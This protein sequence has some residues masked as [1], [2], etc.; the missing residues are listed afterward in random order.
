M[1][2]VTI[3][4]CVCNDVFLN[5]SREEASG[6]EAWGN[7][8]LAP[9]QYL[10]AGHTAMAT[11]D[12]F[13]P[14]QMIQRFDYQNALY[15]KSIASILALPGSLVAGSLLKATS[16]LNPEVREKHALVVA[17]LKTPCVLSNAPLYQES[18]ISV[19]IAREELV[20]LGLA[21]SAEERAHLLQEK[22]AFAAAC[23]LLSQYEIPF[24]ADCGTCL[25]AYRYGGVIPWD[26]DIDLGILQPDFDNVYRILHSLDP[27][28]FVVQDWSNRLYPKTLLRI[29]IKKTKNYIDIYTFSIDKETKSVQFILSHENNSFLPKSWKESQQ[30]YKVATPFTV[31]FPLRRAHFDGIE[32]FVPNQTE[33]YLTM[34]YGENLLP[35]KLYDPKSK[36]YIPDPT[37]PYWNTK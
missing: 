1:P 10:F 26:D 35:S 2:L 27:K 13:I 37:H 8:A 25:G 22:R 16:Y 6:W 11:N 34:R 20:P 21:R 12:P 5:V 15:L 28:E 32:T 19:E 4:H 7:W 24:W 17:S 30:R 3:Y 31:I 9:T 33:K 29:Y 23:A 36:T 14:Y 18:G